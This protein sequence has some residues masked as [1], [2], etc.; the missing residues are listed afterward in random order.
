LHCLLIYYTCDVNICVEIDLGTHMVCAQFCPLEP[1]VTVLPVAVQTSNEVFIFQQLT[2]KI[3]HNV[4]NTEHFCSPNIFAIYQLDHAS[5]HK[6]FEVSFVEF[7]IQILKN[8]AKLASVA[9]S[10]RREDRSLLTLGFRLY[11]FSCNPQR[12]TP[13]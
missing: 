3:K 1:G 12:S 11:K 4:M 8:A 5:I 13:H 10:C 2:D 7:V 6:F 9:E